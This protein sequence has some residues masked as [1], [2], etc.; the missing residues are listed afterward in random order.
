MKRGEHRGARGGLVL[1]G[2]AMQ[3]IAGKYVNARA[4]AATSVI[5]ITCENTF[6]FICGVADEQASSTCRKESRPV[7]RVYSIVCEMW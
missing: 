2:K 6:L 1:K 3:L 4:M 7:G 5:K